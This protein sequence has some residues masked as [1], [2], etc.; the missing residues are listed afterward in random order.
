MYYIRKVAHTPKGAVITTIPKKFADKL[1]LQK[2]KDY[3][4]M[5]LIDDDS[6]KHF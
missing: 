4:K 6:Q 5:E 3:I 1:G 2:P